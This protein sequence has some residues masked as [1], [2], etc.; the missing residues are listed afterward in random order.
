LHWSCG[1]VFCTWVWTH[2]PASQ[3]AVVQALLSVSPQGVLFVAL[4]WVATQMPRSA[5]AGSTS[6]PATLH[7]TGLAAVHGVLGATG[8]HFPLAGSHVPVLHW[9]GVQVFCT[10][11]WTHVPASQPAV[12]H[13]LPSVSVHGPL[14]GALP[15]VA[16]QTPSSAFVGSTSQPAT[17]HS[18]GLAAVHGVLDDTGTQSPVAGS[19]RPVLHWSCVQVFCTCVCTHTASAASRSADPSQPAVV[20]ASLSVSAHGVLFGWFTQVPCPVPPPTGN[21]WAG[22]HTTHSVVQS[23]TR[24]TAP[25]LPVGSPTVSDALLWSVGP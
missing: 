4:L 9:S 24:L 13:A 18:T 8:R 15:W 1:Q 10:C 25:V 19:Q 20:H 14:S 16:T 21:G 3:P 22:S 7:S 17:L 6:Q 11:V 12:V 23:T 2:A 5:F